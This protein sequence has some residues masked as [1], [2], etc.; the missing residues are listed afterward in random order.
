V[1]L[2]QL[3]GMRQLE[4]TLS[5]SSMVAAVVRSTMQPVAGSRAG[6]RDPVATFP[7]R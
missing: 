5:G 1:A 3:V 7:L 6:A 2:K 4:A